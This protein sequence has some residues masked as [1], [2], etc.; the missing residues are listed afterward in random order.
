MT[1]SLDL[2]THE[3]R[4]ESLAPSRD[5]RD[6]AK[7]AREHFASLDSIEI[8]RRAVAGDDNTENLWPILVE[9][10]YPQIGAPENLGGLGDPI[11]LAVLLEESGRALLPA[12]L[13]TTTAAGQLLLAAKLGDSQLGQDHAAFGIANGRVENSL[14]TCER[15]SVLNALGA[16]SVTLL[17]N[18]NSTL[19]VVEVETSSPGVVASSCAHNLDP[20]R[21]FSELSFTNV[22]A[23]QHRQIPS[24]AYNQVL[25]PVRM[26]VAADLV[27]IAAGALD[28]A[29]RHVLARRQFGQ[30]LGQFQAIKHQMSDAYVQVEKARSLMLGTA[31]AVRDQPMQTHTAQLS[32][33]ALGSAAGAAVDVTSRCVQLLGAMGVTFEDDAH[34]YLRRAHQTSLSLESASAAFRAAAEIERATH[35][36]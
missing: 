15:V 29:L 23:R 6:L 36:V 8:T 16:K 21:P 17:V 30:R 18:E 13:M 20:S 10:G 14:V 32:L 19:H 31:V 24:A 35:R 33:L 3:H 26:C 22:P 11:D 9:S 1:S 12:P 34:L 25:S 4:W 28:R 5:A 2:S 27:G 7:T